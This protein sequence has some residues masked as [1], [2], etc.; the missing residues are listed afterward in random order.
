MWGKKFV[1]RKGVGWDVNH[2]QGGES[3]FCP[4]L[5]ESLLVL[6]I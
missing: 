4:P 5:N 6:E 1:C 2:A 3:P